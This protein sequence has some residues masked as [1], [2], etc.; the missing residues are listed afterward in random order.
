MENIYPQDTLLAIVK[1]MIPVVFSR[2]QTLNW[3][4]A[5]RMFIKNVLLDSTTWKGWGKSRTG[6]RKAELQCRPHH[7][8]SKPNRTSEDGHTFIPQP[9]SA[10]KIGWPKEWIVWLWIK[11]QEL[12]SVSFKRYLDATSPCL[13]Q[14]MSDNNLQVNISRKHIKCYR[15][16]LYLLF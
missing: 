16:I 9:S 7:D 3:S 6:R 1:Y 2:N 13:P 15:K 5:Y 12:A 8:L 14:Y 11:R 4:L 10:M